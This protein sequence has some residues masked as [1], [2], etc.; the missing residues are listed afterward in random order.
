MEA[1]DPKLI[2]GGVFRDSRGVLAWWEEGVLPFAPKRV[3]YAT[4]KKGATRG[5]HGHKRLQQVIVCLSGRI[6]ADLKSSTGRSWRFALN[7]LTE[8]VYVPA[9]FWRSVFFEDDS[10]MLVIA[11]LQFDPADYVLGPMGES[12]Q[13]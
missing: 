10:V 13:R 1:E 2:A 6:R 3:Y 12:K 8:G 11:S 5:Q 9:G 7:D 4:G